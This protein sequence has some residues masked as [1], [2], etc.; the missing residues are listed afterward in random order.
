[1]K[2]AEKISGKKTRVGNNGSISKIDDSRDY[3]F[4]FTLKST[5]LIL[6]SGDDILKSDSWKH[7]HYVI[8][9]QK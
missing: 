3:K 4:T 2:V 7:F 5:E 9:M 6:S 8:L 1:M